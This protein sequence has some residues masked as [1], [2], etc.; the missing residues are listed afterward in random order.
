MTSEVPSVLTE[1]DM[2]HTSFTTEVTSDLR[3]STQSLFGQ[4]T[5][6]DSFIWI[7]SILVLII[8][9]SK[10]SGCIALEKTVA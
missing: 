2:I 9:Y 10:I 7:A 1:A 8:L 6:I 3:L 4:Q 5:H